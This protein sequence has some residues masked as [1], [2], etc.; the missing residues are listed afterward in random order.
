MSKR[1][2]KGRV[3][4]GGVGVVMSKRVDK[5]EGDNGRVGCG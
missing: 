4:M 2:D 1:V 3:I 5:G